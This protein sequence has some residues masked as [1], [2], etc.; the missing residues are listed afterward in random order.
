MEIYNDP[1]PVGTEIQNPKK[2]IGKVIHCL[3]SKAT[4]LS[5]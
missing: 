3:S 1:Q 5:N 4:L 2:D